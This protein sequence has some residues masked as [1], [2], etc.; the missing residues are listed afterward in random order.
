MT[1]ANPYDRIFHEVFT[2]RDLLT[3]ALTY[4]HKEYH[5]LVGKIVL[6]RHLG[7]SAYLEKK[8]VHFYYP[9]SLTEEPGL[10]GYQLRYDSLF[11][12]MVY[13]PRAT[14]PQLDHFLRLLTDYL[15]RNF[16]ERLIRQ[17]LGHTVII[18]GHSEAMM[19]AL[20]LVEAYAPLREP[21]HIWGETG[22]GKDLIAMALHCRSPRADKPFIT[23]NCS[24]FTDPHSMM[25]E[26]FGIVDS[27]G[28]KKGALELAQEGTLYIQDVGYLP[29][30]VQTHLNEALESQTYRRIGDSTLQTIQARIITSCSENLRLRAEVNQFRRDLYDF[31]T[32]FEIH[33]LPLRKRPED[34]LSIGEHILHR[35]AMENRY[36]YRRLSREAYM[37]LASYNFPGNIRELI[38]ILKRAAV[39]A[40]GE[41][42]APEDLDFPEFEVAEDR[43][44]RAFQEMAEK[45]KNFW[46]AVKKPFMERE[47][48]KTQLRHIV[49]HGLKLTN[50]SYKQLCTLF[51]LPEKDYHRFMAFIHR[52]LH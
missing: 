19:Q 48:N 47:L 12:G 31:L 6:P 46:E 36:P 35:F 26:I 40:K 37:K 42:I 41:E 50:G 4:L 51:K 10:R 23:I 21:V 7:E 1:K 25:A 24:G 9:E 28:I 22:T 30:P 38:R 44:M 17:H 39:H 16:L 13:L 43:E 14:Y 8:E 5:L 52:N 33:L 18:E 49:E 29:L 45:G 32:P 27:E 15:H 20:E 3:Q 11:L 34:I 2:L